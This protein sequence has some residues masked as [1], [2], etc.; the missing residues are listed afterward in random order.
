MEIRQMKVGKNSRRGTKPVPTQ[1]EPLALHKILNFGALPLSC[2]CY[3]WEG[4]SSTFIAPPHAGTGAACRA[5]S[6]ELLVI[7]SPHL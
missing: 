7:S 1:H 5:R 2:G 6:G 3:I 4:E